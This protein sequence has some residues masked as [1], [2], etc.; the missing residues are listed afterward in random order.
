LTKFCLGLKK[1][2][3]YAAMHAHG[4]GASGSGFVKAYTDHVECPTLQIFSFFK[5]GKL[6]ARC[7]T[8]MAD[9]ANLRKYVSDPSTFDASTVVPDA[10]ILE[11]F[12]KRTK[13]FGDIFNGQTEAEIIVMLKK[14]NNSAPD[15]CLDIIEKIEAK[16]F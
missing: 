12:M 4:T 14:Y 7:K 6:A 2:D 5:I 1:Y 8:R 16:G 9:R 11:N 3:H 15:V 13:K 10:T